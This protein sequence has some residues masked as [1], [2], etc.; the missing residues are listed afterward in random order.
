MATSLYIDLVANR[1]VKSLYSIAPINPSGLIRGDVLDLNLELSELGRD[2]LRATQAS[3]D[4][5][6]L[7]RADAAANFD[8]VDMGCV[9][10]FLWPDVG[11]HVCMGN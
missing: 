11:S 1:L 5:L 9:F 2:E 7:A 4:V 6:V 3:Y 8:E 10:E